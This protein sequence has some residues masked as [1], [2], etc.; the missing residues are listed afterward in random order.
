MTSIQA[1]IS[2]GDDVEG[3]AE[4]NSWATQ[5]RGQV[6]SKWGQLD[7]CPGSTAR[8]SMAGMTVQILTL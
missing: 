6:Q 2:V 3:Q 4:L 7:W 5:R 8:N 1:G